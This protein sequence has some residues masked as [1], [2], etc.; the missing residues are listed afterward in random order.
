MKDSERSKEA[1]RDERV[2]ERRRAGNADV[3]MV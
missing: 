2:L 3:E 1:W